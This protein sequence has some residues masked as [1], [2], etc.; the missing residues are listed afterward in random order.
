MIALDTNVIVRVITRDDEA[1]A[2]RGAAL[3][4]E[5]DLWLSKTVLL[6]TEWVLRFTYEYDA[7]NVGL[8]L[9]KLLGLQ[10]LTV[11]EPHAVERALAWHREGMDFADAL[12]LASSGS[13][14]RFATFDRRMA[15]S[16]ARAPGAIP[17][18]LL[19]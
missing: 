11:E 12:H 15:K 6:E 16:V 4:R 18:E 5:N 14:E 13:A 1:Q 3:M 8:A 10:N 9:S 7:A 19:K 17:V 2:R